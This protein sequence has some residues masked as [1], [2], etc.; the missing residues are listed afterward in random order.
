[1]KDIRIS[2]FRNKITLL[3]AEV[4]T[5]AEMNRTERMVRGRT[6][7]ANIEVKTANVDNT[8]A[9][10]R[11]ELHYKIYI[12]AQ[13]VQFDYIEYNGKVLQLTAPYYVVDNK[14]ICIN[15]VEIKG[16]TWQ[17]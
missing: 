15:A 1:M 4:T 16:K 17:Q 10:T 3:T 6:V 7:W 12:R 13:S 11:P 9:G 14:Y 2:D 8:T 5:D